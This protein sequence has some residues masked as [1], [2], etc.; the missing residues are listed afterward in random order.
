MNL[1]SVESIKS[2]FDLANMTEEELQEKINELNFTSNLISNSLDRA[3]T[4]YKSVIG[5]EAEAQQIQFS[6]TVE[7]LDS[8]N[9]SEGL[10]LF[11]YLFGY[12]E[13]K[14]FLPAEIS[15]SNIINIL[16]ASGSKISP[17]SEDVLYF[18]A[19]KPSKKS[20]KPEIKNSNNANK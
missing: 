7:L 20:V 11:T 12:Y 1:A 18:L 6:D 17:N 4:V 8:L 10:R 14:I 16:S 15:L 19:R 9:D 5:A 2:Y 13:N 3:L